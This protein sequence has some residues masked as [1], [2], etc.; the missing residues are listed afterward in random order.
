MYNFLKL[1]IL[2][3]L[4]S[5]FCIDTTQFETGDI[6]ANTFSLIFFLHQTSVLFTLLKCMYQY[7]MNISPF[8]K[9]LMI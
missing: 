3:N 6:C 9:I 8:S 4:Y 1:F 7:G 2:Y 5:N